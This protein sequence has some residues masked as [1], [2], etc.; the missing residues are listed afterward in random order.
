MRLQFVVTSLEKKFSIQDFLNQF[1]V[2]NKD[3]TKIKKELIDSFSRLKDSQLIENKFR[4]TFKNGS[5]REVRQVENLSPR[6]LSKSESLSF[7]EII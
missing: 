2:P 6:M 7:W 1:S 3:L 4:L 5:S